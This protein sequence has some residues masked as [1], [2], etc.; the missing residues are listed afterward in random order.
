[1]M[2]VSLLVNFEDGSRDE[3]RLAGVRTDSAY[4]AQAL[5]AVAPG[6]EVF[7][8]PDTQ[9]RDADGRLLGHVYLSDGTLLQA[10]WTD[11]RRPDDHGYDDPL[12][13]LD[14]AVLHGDFY[15]TLRWEAPGPIPAWK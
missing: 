4:A 5:A 7:V 2:T 15:Q 6:T 12:V 8:E 9:G 10:L 14:A 11:L 1:M 3:V 13:Y